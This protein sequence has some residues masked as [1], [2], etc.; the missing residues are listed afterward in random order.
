MITADTIRG[1]LVIKNHRPLELSTYSMQS[2]VSV[3][4]NSQY[5]GW[6]LIL[7]F[8]SAMA[9]I[10]CQM[11]HPIYLIKVTLSKMN[12]LNGVLISA[13]GFP[14][15]YPTPDR[16]LA[17]YAVGSSPTTEASIVWSVES[18]SLSLFRAFQCQILNCYFS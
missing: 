14:V 17:H 6:E 10:L 8:L 11:G 16:W 2:V 4:A 15:S 9:P 13:L 1:F 3:R 7:L 18:G 5:R 12:T